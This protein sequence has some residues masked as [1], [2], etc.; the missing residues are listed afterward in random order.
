MREILAQDITNAIARL[1]ERANFDL[2][3]DFVTALRAGAQRERSERGRTV[4]QLLDRNQELARQTRV[5]SCQDTGFVL[6]F[7]ELGQDARVTG[8]E[9]EAAIQAGVAKGYTE[10]YLRASIV[11]DPLF[12]RRNTRDNTPAVVYTEFV[13]GDQ[14]KLTVLVKGAG[15]EN[16]TALAMLPPAAGPEGVIKFVVESVQKAGPNSCPPLVVCV[17][18]GGTADKAMLIAKKASLRKLG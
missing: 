4:L 13:P 6:I 1:C 10:H 12:D 9:L 2:P 16:S 3:H 8:G 14:L 17:G 7:A 15:S 5:P 11:D 18:V